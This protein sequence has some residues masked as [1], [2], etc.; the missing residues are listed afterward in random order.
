MGGDQLRGGL[1]YFLLVCLRG[2]FLVFL[3]LFFLVCFFA[4]RLAGEW[5]WVVTNSMVGG[6]GEGDGGGGGSGCHWLMPLSLF[7]QEDLNAHESF[8][9]FLSSRLSAHA[10]TVIT[11]APHNHTSLS[12]VAWCPLLPSSLLIVQQ[13]LPSAFPSLF[14]PP[15][16]HSQLVIQPS[17]FAPP[18]SDSQRLRDSL[19]PAPRLRPR[20]VAVHTHPDR[21]R[22]RLP[23]C[24]RDLP[25]DTR[26]RRDHARH[27]GQ[28]GAGKPNAFIVACGGGKEEG[29]LARV[30]RE[31]PPPLRCHVRLPSG[32]SSN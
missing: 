29:M 23:G 14:P 4:K 6:A 15:H 22:A 10:H 24:A 26:A 11:H 1:S 20:G 17:P 13:S 16:P 21:R 5:Q 32:I 25:R 9:S 8:V 30:G 2:L 12:R 18:P 3:C 27:G 31:S 28:G 19:L 7:S